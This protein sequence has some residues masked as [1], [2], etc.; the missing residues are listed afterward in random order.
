MQL[1]RYLIAQSF[2]LC[3]KAKLSR[4]KIDNI[5]IDTIFD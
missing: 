1:V 5:L 4:K 3:E 2:K